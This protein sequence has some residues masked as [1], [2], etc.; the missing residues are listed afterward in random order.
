MSQENVEVV[1]RHIDAYLSGDYEAALEAYH[2]EVVCD[3]TVRP[4]GRVYWG[5]EGVI[6]A[7][8]VWR[9]T[10]GTGRAGSKR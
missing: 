7:F 2:P 9:G 8:R 3:A 6:E 1:R 10:W 4:E 5:R